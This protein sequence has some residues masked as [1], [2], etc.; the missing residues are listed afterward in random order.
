MYLFCIDKITEKLQV[1]IHTLI[2]FSEQ[3]CF[4][5]SLNEV[6]QTLGIIKH[7]EKNN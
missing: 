2:D 1:Y 7:S 5:L 3:I 6:T 4:V